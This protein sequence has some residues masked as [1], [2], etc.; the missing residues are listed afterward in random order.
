MRSIPENEL[1]FTFSRSSGKGGQ[2]VNKVESRVQLRWNPERS[3]ALSSDDKMFIKKSLGGRLKHKGDILV[4][5]D[6]KR[7][8]FANLAI[9]RHKLLSLVQNALKR[10][11][12]RLK[13]RPTRSS[14]LNRLEKKRKLSIKKR[15]RKLVIDN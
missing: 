7:S 14:R 1:E 10:P 15:N 3:A 2:N 12:N 13:T 11:K 5:C 4:T 6:E 9:A 8:Q